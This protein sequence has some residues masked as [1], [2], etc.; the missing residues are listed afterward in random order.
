MQQVI[1]DDEAHYDT[2]II[3]NSFDDSEGGVEPSSSHTHMGIG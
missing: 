3:P 1:Y 2:V